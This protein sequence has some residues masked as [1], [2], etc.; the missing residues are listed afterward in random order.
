MSVSL[1]AAASPA[2]PTDPLALERAALPGFSAAPDASRALVVLSR[3]RCRTGVA[4][5]ALLVGLEDKPLLLLGLG[6]WIVANMG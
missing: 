2:G 4:T 1:H 5:G 6:S 3:G